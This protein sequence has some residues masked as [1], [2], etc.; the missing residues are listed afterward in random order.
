[1]RTTV[2]GLLAAVLLAACED[3]PMD[4]DYRKDAG[5]KAV[6]DAG[7]DAGATPATD[8]GSDGAAGSSGDS[9]AGDEDA[10]DA[11]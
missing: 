6:E 1:M 7:H 5:A 8:A 10:G 4:L 11:G 2:L 9:D 3:D